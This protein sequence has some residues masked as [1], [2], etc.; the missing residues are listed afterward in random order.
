MVKK[1]IDIS[2]VY[3]KKTD[4]IPVPITFVY[5]DDTSETI[6]AYKIANDDE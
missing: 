1:T 5:A 2:E 3:L 6:T 4:L